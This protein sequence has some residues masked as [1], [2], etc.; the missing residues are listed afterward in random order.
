MA[1][2][3]GSSK[4]K[5]ELG[6]ETPCLLIFLFIVWNISPGCSSWPPSKWGFIFIQSAVFRALLTLLLQMISYSFLVVTSLQFI[7]SF[8][9]SHYLARHQVWTSIHKSHPSSL[10][11]LVKLLSNPFFLHLASKRAVFLSPTLEFL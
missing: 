7:A 2:S 8:N 3:M 5:V 11:E 4:G 9:S 10:G 6:K 1:T